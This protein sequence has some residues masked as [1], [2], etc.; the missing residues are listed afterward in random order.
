[1]L[2]GAISFEILN[3]MGCHIDKR[4]IFHVETPLHRKEMISWVN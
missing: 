3:F 2:R 1:M 4:P